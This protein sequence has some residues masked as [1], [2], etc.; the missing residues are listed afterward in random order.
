MD[1]DLGIGQPCSSVLPASQRPLTDS[2]QHPSTRGGTLAWLAPAHLAGPD[3]AQEAALVPHLPATSPPS[4][5][6]TAGGS[7]PAG[8][9][10][11]FEAT[12]GPIRE[13]TAA[14]TLEGGRLMRCR[15][16]AS[17]FCHSASTLSQ[18]DSVPLQD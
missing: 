14:S 17:P 16:H 13:A 9:M 5:H 18:D 6:A 10:G 1:L 3:E 2:P 7:S 15:L 12:H 11:P 8:L 4:A